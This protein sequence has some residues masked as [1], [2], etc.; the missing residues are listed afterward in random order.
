MTV[1][2]IAIAAIII[3]IETAAAIVV[4]VVDVPVK[5]NNDKVINQHG[6]SLA[7]WMISHSSASFEWLH[8]QCTTNQ[9]TYSP[10]L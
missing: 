10:C 1:T 2:T 3:E 4:P 8:S 5:Q 7:Y 9:W 6:V